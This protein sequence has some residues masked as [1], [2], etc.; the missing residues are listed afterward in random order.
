MGST[1]RSCQQSFKNTPY[2]YS[3][4]FISFLLQPCHCHFSPGTS[5]HCFASSH[6]ALQSILQI[7]NLNG[8]SRTQS[9]HSST[10]N[11]PVA[12]HGPYTTHHS[13]A[14]Q[15]F[16]HL[17][18]PM[19]HPDLGACLLR[20]RAFRLLRYTNWIPSSGPLHL[21]VAS[22]VWKVLP[23]DLYD[24]QCTIHFSAPLLVFT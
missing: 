13:A 6:L 21:L 14:W 19:P 9:C 3:L 2:T 8:F 1:S 17:S 12:P 15:A 5:P 18:L 16:H 22:F 20:S 24:Y 7:A 23:Q 4:L 11:S 10:F